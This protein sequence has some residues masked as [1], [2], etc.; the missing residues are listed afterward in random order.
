MNFVGVIPARYSSTRFPGKPLALIKGKPLIQHVYEQVTKSRELQSV[1]VATDHKEIEAI[2]KQFGGQVIM[3]STSHETG[4]D[5]IAEVTTKTNG[6]FFVNIQG[7][8]PLIQADLIDELI[9]QAKVTPSAVITAKTKIKAKEDIENPN[10]VKVV[11]DKN[12]KALYFSRSPIPYNRSKKEINYYKHLGIYC[13]PKTILQEFVRTEPTPYEQVEVLE[14]LRMLE[15]GISIYVVETENDAIGVD[16]PEDIEK[17]EK[18][19]GGK[20]NGQ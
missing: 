14:Q 4:S 20:Y 17:V 10:V 9:K 2:V 3:T 16:T 7:D 5:R 13:Y 18:Y 19:L 1:I 15:S 12:G 6:D 8:E 11:T